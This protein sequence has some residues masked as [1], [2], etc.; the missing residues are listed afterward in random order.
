MTVAKQD[1]ARVTVVGGGPVGMVAA[2]G[3]ARL[4][5]P[6][7]LLEQGPDEVRSDWR[8]STIHPPTLEMLDLLGVGRT[9][10]SGAVQVDRLEY[11]DLELDERVT[12][13]YELLTDLTPHPFRL[14]FEQYKLVRLLREAIAVTADIDMRFEHEVVGIVQDDGRAELE[15]QT[16][17]GRQVLCSEWVVAADGAHSTMRKLLEV[18]FPGFTY[19]FQSVVVATQFAFG[20]VVPDLGAVCY[21]SG[22]R[23]RFSLIRTPDI[24]RAAVTTGTR[25]DEEFDTTVGPHPD[26]VAGVELL[27]ARRVDPATLQLSQNQ[28]YRSHQRLAAS[29]RFGQVLLAGDAAHLSSTTGGMGLNS[30]VHDAMAIAEALASPSPDQAADVYSHRRR[31]VAEEH[32]QPTTTENRNAGDNLDLADRRARLARLARVAEDEF[33]AR[34]YLRRASMIGIQH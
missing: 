23:G 7:L 33:T 32:V 27:L 10:E 25:V 24:W 28:M 15:V 18:D 8:G 34:D 21:W 17:D 13:S 20:D 2:L 4:G 19:P 5:I 14:Q 11:R 22:P 9:V 26:F 16:P 1:D 6:S 30:G 29:F 31:V 3:L 12:F